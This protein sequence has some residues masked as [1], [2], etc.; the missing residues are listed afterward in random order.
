MRG[1]DLYFSTNGYP[2]E[3]SVGPETNRKSKPLQCSNDEHTI[4]EEKLNEYF[5]HGYDVLPHNTY[6][7]VEYIPA[8]FI[9]HEHHVFKYAGKHGE[10]I[11]VA[12]APEKLLPNSI[13]TP[14]K[15]TA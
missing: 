9:E 4:P 10:G 5:P 13:L 8:K 1:M 12:D 11:R 15:P 14:T 7:T 6:Y 2:M 3:H